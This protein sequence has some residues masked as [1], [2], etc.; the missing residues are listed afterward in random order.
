MV[1]VVERQ[2][3]AILGIAYRGVRGQARPDID[4][5]VRQPQRQK[6]L[7]AHELG[8]ALARSPGDDLVQQSIAQVGI[9]KGLARLVHQVAIAADRLVH[10]R[11]AERL[12]DVEELIVQRQA[13]R[14]VGQPPQ[15]GAARVTHVRRQPG[16]A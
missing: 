5:H 6:H 7:G 12:V 11:P 14:M 2:W 16:L 8:I 9:T 3:R 1:E 15:R 13:R 4:R 10:R